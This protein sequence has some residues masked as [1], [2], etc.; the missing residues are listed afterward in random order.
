MKKVIVKTASKT[1][2]VVISNSNL[3]QLPHFLSKEK[4]PGNLFVVV[5]KNVFKFHSKTIKSIFKNY[6]GKI[7]FYQIPSGEKYKSKE[8]LENIYESLLKNHYGR[9]TTL[10]AFGGGVT[11]DLAAF[12]ASTYMRGLPFINVPTTLLAMIDSAIGGKTGINFNEKKNIIGTFYQPQLVFIDTKF[13]ETLPE[14][15]FSSALGEL[16]KY[17]LIS[18]KAFLDFLTKNFDK[19]KSKEKDSINHAI[20]ESVKFKA[21]VVSQDEFERKGIR[22]ILNLGHTFAHGFESNLKFRI[23]HGEAVTAGIV[24]ALFLSEKIKLLN[25]NVI[26]NLLVLPSKIKMSKQ[27]QKLNYESVFEIMMSDKKVED[28]QLKLVLISGIGESIVD[29]PALK[30]DVFFAIDKMKKFFSV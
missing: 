17:G 18:N 6:N 28:G 29:A 12:A 25:S 2:P 23:K 21:G 20:T 24:C 27:I 7:H 26:D 30:K 14:S 19:I 11:G 5:D 4:L 1:Y 8:Q 9:D 16:I 3:N 15:E 13:L 22:K 10:I